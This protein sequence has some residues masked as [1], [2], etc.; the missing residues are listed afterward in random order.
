MDELKN[1]IICIAGI[2]TSIKNI[3]DMRQQKNKNR[4]RNEVL[5]AKAGKPDALKNE[6]QGD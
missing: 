5:S 3:Y 4:Q 1:W 6:L 2:V